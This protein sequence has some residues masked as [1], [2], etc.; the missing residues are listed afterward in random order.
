MSPRTGR[1]RLW[2]A[3]VR[4]RVTLAATAVTLLGGLIGAVLFVGGLHQKL[5]QSLV[6]SAQQQT[7]TV[8]AQLNAGGTPDQVTV[9]DKRDIIVQVIDKKDT[10]VASDHG[11]I[12]KPLR[13]SPGVTERVDVPT[14]DDTYA[15]YA[16]LAKKG[17]LVLV[18]LSEEQVTRA[19]STAIVLLAIALPLGILMLAGVVWLSIGRALRPVEV[20]RREAAAITSEDLH[21]RL[22]EPPGDD[23][24]PLLAA[25]LNEMLDRIDLSQRQQRQFVSDASHELRSP[26]ATM[27]Q[28]A[29]VA[30]RHP[31]ST[32]VEELADDVLAEEI[33]ME[34]LVKALLILAR[35][36]DRASIRASVV[37]LDDAV[38]QEVDRLRAQRADEGITFDISRVSAGQSYGDPVLFGQVV[39][40]LVSN[41]ARHA[42][43]VVRVSLDEE[44]AEVVLVVEDDG[45]GIPE[46][47]R[48]RVFDRFTRLDES[49]ARDA[50]GAGL[51]LAIV[52]KVVAASHG[53]VHVATSDLGGARFVVKL[54][55]HADQAGA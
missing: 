8:V 2:L 51:G 18:G 14:L 12:T 16:K 27:R 22:A 49:R 29:E 50:G 3:R 54:P 52:E 1:V 6:S 53:S 4:V 35:L 32:S 40:N 39:T 13:T 48:E 44:G 10:V 23:E 41:A 26:L 55:A 47:D 43:S 20:M 15:V 33:R 30:Q 19:T 17:D 7:A 37:D 36:D 28:M 11:W 42:S 24:I 9:T 38:L 45:A 25:T 21:E 31:E 5:E 46:S 34:G